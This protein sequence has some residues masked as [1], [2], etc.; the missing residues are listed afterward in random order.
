MRTT[1]TTSVD[2]ELKAQVMPI[3]KDKGESL[4]TIMDEVFKKIIKENK[5][6]DNKPRA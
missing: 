3:L 2:C 6:D 1:I 5:R 4:G